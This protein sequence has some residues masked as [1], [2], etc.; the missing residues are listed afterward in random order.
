MGTTFSIFTVLNWQIFW[1]YLI[2]NLFIV[3]QP[4]VRSVR[5]GVLRNFAQFTGKHLCQSLIFNRVAGLR[6]AILLKKKLWHKCFPVKFAKFLRT[7]FLQ[8]PSAS[9]WSYGF[10]GNVRLSLWSLLKIFQK[11]L[12]FVVVFL[13]DDILVFLKYHQ[14]TISLHVL[15]QLLYGNS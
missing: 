7:P 8:N 3:K 6:S 9:D 4:S 5:K 2:N 1:N 12:F 11:I 15:L 13:N 10:I 14:C